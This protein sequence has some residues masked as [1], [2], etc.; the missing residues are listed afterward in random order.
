M[1]QIETVA[2]ESTRFTVDDMCH[3]A[4]KLIARHGADAAGI[5]DYFARECRILGDDTRAE[6]WDA[7]QY[8]VA[9]I[10]AGQPLETNPTLH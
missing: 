3:M 2:S 9:D 5:A 10:L 1:S 6:A 8:L 7:V 4:I